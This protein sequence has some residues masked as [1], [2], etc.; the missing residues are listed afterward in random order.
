MLHQQHL[1]TEDF[2]TAVL[3][4]HAVLDAEAAATGGG[5]ILCLAITPWLMGQPHRI[6]ALG[7][8]LDTLVA[9]GGLWPATGT[10]ILTAWRAGAG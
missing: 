8:L 10:E 3:A 5:R 1:A 6:Q 4:A 9:R 7:G 2:T